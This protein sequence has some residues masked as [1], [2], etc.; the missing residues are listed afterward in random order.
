MATYGSLSSASVDHTRSCGPGT[1][2]VRFGQ[3]LPM[4][5]RETDSLH[6]AP[7]AAITTLVAFTQKQ[8]SRFITCLC[9]RWGHDSACS[10]LRQCRPPKV[11]FNPPPVRGGDLPGRMAD[12]AF[13]LVF[14][15]TF[16][17]L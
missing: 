17:P 16:E 12:I 14:L 7:N 10:A 1:V 9:A 15:C 2:V 13:G 11:G 3:N 5:H 4:G 6:R 8:S